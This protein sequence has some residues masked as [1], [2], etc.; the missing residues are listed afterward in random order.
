MMVEGGVVIFLKTFLPGRDCPPLGWGLE[1]C[2]VKGNLQERDESE[3]VEREGDFLQ[4][5]LPVPCLEPAA[6]NRTSTSC[7]LKST[8]LHGGAAQATR[9]VLT[10]QRCWENSTTR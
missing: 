4:R 9:L 2:H 7:I 10:V 1:V 6:T 8:L 5:A 3:G